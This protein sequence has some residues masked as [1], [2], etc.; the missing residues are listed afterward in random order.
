M[1]V[2][3]YMSIFEIFSISREKIKKWGANKNI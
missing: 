1:Q 3:L 2:I